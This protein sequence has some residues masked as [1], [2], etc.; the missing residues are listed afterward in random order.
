[1]SVFCFH[2][3]GRDAKGAALALFTAR[4]H[5]P[6][7]TTHKAVLQAI[8]YQLDKAIERF[9]AS[10]LTLRLR[11]PLFVLFV[12]MVWKLKTALIL[13]CCELFPNV[14][15][16]LFSQ[17]KIFIFLHQPS[18]SVHFFLVYKLK[19]MDSYLSTT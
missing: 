10:L 1:M 12:Q 17:R 18:R 13:L 2:Q 5:R 4:L 9:D 11:W 16:Y 19:E 6:D 8:I 14:S 15:Y 3:P 7:V